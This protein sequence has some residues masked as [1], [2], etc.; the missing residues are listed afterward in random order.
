[1]NVVVIGFVYLLEVKCRFSFEYYVNKGKQG[2]II[3]LISY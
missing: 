2:D 1:M 3:R